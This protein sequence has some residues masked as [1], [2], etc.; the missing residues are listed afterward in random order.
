MRNIYP[1]FLLGLRIHGLSRVVIHDFRNRSEKVHNL[2]TINPELRLFRELRNQ[3]Y[4]SIDLPYRTN[5]N[6]KRRNPFYGHRFIL[7]TLHIL[8]FQCKRYWKKLITINYSGR[9]PRKI[10]DWRKG[11]SLMSRMM[12]HLLGL[13]THFRCSA[14]TKTYSDT[15]TSWMKSNPKLIQLLK[16]LNGSKKLSP[17]ICKIF[18]MKPR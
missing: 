11:H 10:V 6:P 15:I 2:W 5:L 9:T 17:H 14:L 4:G 1:G 3:I 12:A 8:Y 18:I 13:I 16:N 7:T